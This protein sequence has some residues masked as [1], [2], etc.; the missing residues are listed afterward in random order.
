M[1]QIRNLALL[2]I[3]G[4]LA[5]LGQ[6]CASKSGSLIGQDLTGQEERISA[7]AIKEIPGASKAN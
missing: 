3:T 2:S 5:L 1:I 7:P 4:I 6:S